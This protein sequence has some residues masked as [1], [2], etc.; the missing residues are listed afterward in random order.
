[1]PDDSFYRVDDLTTRE[2]LLPVLHKLYEYES[3]IISG[4][5]GGLRRFSQCIWTKENAINYIN[6]NSNLENVSEK[7]DELIEDMSSLESRHMLK[8]ELNGTTHHI[9]RV[10]EMIRTTGNLHEYANREKLTEDG[11]MDIPKKY[12]IIEGTRWEPR[13][14]YSARRE[15]SKEQILD[16]VKSKFDSNDRLPENMGEIPVSLA[17]EDLERVLDAVIKALIAKIEKEGEEFEG[18]IRFSKFQVEAITESVRQSWKSQKETKS[19]IVLTAGTGVG[20][21]LGFAIPVITDALIANRIGGNV[22]SQLLMYPRNALAKDQYSEIEGYVKRVN[23]SLISDG[24]RERCIGIA[25]DAD[26]LIKKPRN[27]YPATGTQNL[28]EWNVGGKNAYESA[29]EIYGGDKPASIIACSVESFRRRLKIPEVTKGLRRGLRRIVFDEV[30]L[31]SGIQGGHHSQLISRCKQLL[32]EKNPDSLIYK[33]RS[34]SLNFIGVSATIAKPREHVG[35]ISGDDAT[36]VVHIDAG[37]NQASNNSPLGI[38]NHVLIHPRKGTPLTG[39]LVD[40]TSALTHQRRSRDFHLRGDPLTGKKKYK[41]LQKTIGFADSHEVVGNWHSLLLDNESTARDRRR[42]VNDE[43][44]RVRRPYAHWH[45]RPLRIHDGG[46]DVCN[47]CQNMNHHATPINIA[48]DDIGKFRERTDDSL[49]GNNSSWNITLYKDVEE[50]INVTGLETCPHLEVGTCWWFSPREENFEDRPDNIGYKSFQEIIRAT[51]Y[52]GKTKPESEDD[53]VEMTSANFAFK[54]DPAR[55][56]YERVRTED[57]GS[58]TPVAHDIAIATPTLEVGVD[59]DN[60]SEVITHKAIRNISSY[61]QKIGRGGREP[62]S[63]AVAMTMMSMG[64][65]DFQHY[66]SMNRLVDMQIT[67]PVPIAKNNIA[68]KKNQAY[69]SVFDYLSKLGHDIELIPTLKQQKPTSDDYHLWTGMVSKIELAIDSICNKNNE[70]EVISIN[71]SCDIYVR[72]ATGI[73]NHEWRNEAAITVAKHLKMI[74]QKTLQGSTVIQWLAAKKA[75]ETLSEGLPGDNA[76]LWPQIEKA[77]KDIKIKINCPDDDYKNCLD[78][79]ELSVELRDVNSLK[80]LVPELLIICER[81]D[82]NEYSI[83]VLAAYTEGL[84]EQRMEPE[85]CRQI[86]KLD[87]GR[88]WYLSSV[89]ESCPIFQKDTPYSPLSTLFQNP[90]EKPVEV[91]RYRGQPDLITNKEALKY[92]LPGMWTHRLFRGERYFVKHSGDLNLVGDNKYFS[93]KLDGNSHCPELEQLGSISEEEADRIPEILDLPAEKDMKLYKIV[94]LHVRKDRGSGNRS[95]S[96]QAGSG[97]YSGLMQDQGGQGDVIEGRDGDLLRPKAHSISWKLSKLSQNKDELDDVTTYK[98]ANTVPSTNGQPEYYNVTEHPLL[99][100]MFEKIVYDQNMGVRRLALGVK[101][102]NGPVLAPTRNEKNIA[103]VDEIKTNGIRFQIK[104]EFMEK[105]DKCGS[106]KN[107]QFDDRVLMMLGSWILSRKDEFNTNSWTVNEYLDILVQESFRLSND[108]SKAETLPKTN[109]EFIR[110]VF[111]SG[112][113]FE[114]EVFERRAKYSAITGD[115]QLRDIVGDLKQLDRE[116]A[117]SDTFNN[118]I[119]DNLD[120]NMSKWYR[121]TLLNTLGLIIAESVNELA[122]VQTGSIGYTYN[123]NN[124]E[125]WIDIFDDDA[126]GNGSVELTK[127]YF[128]IP[129]EIRDLAQHFSE[130]YNSNLPSNT[131]VEILER[132]LQTCQ[133]HIL[134]EIST[135]KSRIPDRVVSWM[136]KEAKEIKNRFGE[137]WDKLAVTNTR[138]AALHNRRRFSINENQDR[139]ELLDLEMALSLCSTECPSCSGDDFI[140]LLPPHLV[141]YGTCRAV[142]D[143][144]LGDLTNIEGYKM[145]FRDYEE[146][147]NISGNN[148][149]S[150]RF[151]NI[152]GKKPNS[153]GVLKHFVH[154]PCPPV[155]YS[156]RRGMEIPEEIDFLVRHMEIL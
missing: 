116:L 102:S 142:L 112:E 46:S 3:S 61:R 85:I 135:S 119:V 45:E 28:L 66:R 99:N 115:K 90:H 86:L 42:P 39:A 51:R 122:G 111:A 125:S 24:E 62:G 40:M 114:E 17:F 149:P 19:S 14:R 27:K 22:C 93:M 59:M 72:C 64:N 75:G 60:V 7:I 118:E 126:E 134:H 36:D 65:N 83:K 101:R 26:S 100:H 94:K 144:V 5:H 110:L 117:N 70:G 89:M 63:D 32:Y 78:A 103:L 25:I 11:G 130:N 96:V 140:N 52:T 108:E 54:Q 53:G 84:E 123:D 6:S 153:L 150:N 74:L 49:S 105:A 57:D 13:L 47:S 88:R 56:A 120:E 141:N 121:S 136:E 48:K 1:M 9:T 92:T 138:E 71:Y 20:K 143:E 154:Y 4:S 33:D 34:K 69:E 44:K 104:R 31:S 73:E 18:E 43:N 107:H 156:W 148:V 2:R 91:Y 133:E 82:I 58:P 77:I 41:S 147:A 155:A 30:H 10:A 15:Y 109:A 113:G 151:I 23:Q 29:S 139:T 87:K 128:H 37:S 79:I 50:S 55:G 80:T 16:I 38:M 127:T 12:R 76:D 137:S 98:I 129:I 146:L 67:D 95:N 81:H 131:F 35:I 8:F 97:D 106:N 152:K 21:T 68:V 132:R 124:E 145:Q